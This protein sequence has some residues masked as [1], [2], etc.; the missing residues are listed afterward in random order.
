MGTR[1][2]ASCRQAQGLR[3]GQRAPVVRCVELFCL[4]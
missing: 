2:I 3:Q 4:C 1:A